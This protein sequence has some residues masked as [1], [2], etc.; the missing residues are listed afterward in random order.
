LKSTDTITESSRPSKTVVADT[1]TL[2]KARLSLLVVLSAALGYL[3]GAEQ[4]NWLTLSLLSI[5]GFLLTGGS[6][7]LNQVWERHADA[8][9]ERTK[10]RPLP[11]G[12]MTPMT[13]A[14][15]S[16]I[17]AVAGIL[18]LWI[19]VNQIA[20]ILGLLAFFTYVFVYTPMK[21]RTSMAVFVGAFPGAIPPMLGYVAATGVF[22]LEPGILFAVQFFWQF[23]HFWAIAWVADED[24][25]KA[26]FNL[27]PFPEGRS[28]RSS[29]QILLYSLFLIPVGMLAWALPGEPMIGWI[30]LAVSM[31]GGAGMAWAAW[32]LYLSNSIRDAKV[33]MFA[34]FAYLP[35]VQL[36]YVIDKA[37]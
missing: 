30:A 19:G 27:L 17:A 11:A 13:A 21:M 12:R 16:G 23:P 5:G 7:G 1:L 25:R 6:G 2:F 37:L 36:I 29:H 4:T 22:G 35:L 8:M 10:K 33:L 32:R 26:G 24:Y 3:M 28:K 31:A 18:I 14:L 9:M 15:I 20:G 34:S